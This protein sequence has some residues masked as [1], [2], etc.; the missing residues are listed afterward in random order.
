MQGLIFASFPAGTTATAPFIGSTISRLG[1]R[2]TV[3]VG[4]GCMSVFTILFG[5]TPTLVSDELVPFFLVVFGLLY[6]AGSS[7]AESGTFAILSNSFPDDLGKVLAAS[8]VVTGLGA[9]CGP[10]LGGLMYGAFD[11][12]GEA[13]Q[14]MYTTMAFG[15]T[16]LLGI[17]LLVY[18]MPQVLLIDCTINR[19]Y[20]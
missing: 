11:R 6:G 12:V 18:Y 14:F 2:T 5:F 17:S 13:R 20:Y 7:F 9:M 4:L 10:F 16:P 15:A 3:I 8:E 19:L 1:A